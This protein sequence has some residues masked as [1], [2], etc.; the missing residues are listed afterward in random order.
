MMTPS[1]GPSTLAI[2]SEH[3]AFLKQFCAELADRQRHMRRLERQRDRQ[4]RAANADNYRPAGRVKPG[5]LTWHKSGRQRR[6]DARLAEL[7]RQLAAHRQSLH[8]QLVNDILA[9]GDQIYLEQLSY[10]AFQRRFG[11]SVGADGVC[12]WRVLQN[13]YDPIGRVRRAYSCHT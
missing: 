5:S 11:R 10:R 2:V 13:S 3:A 9:L 8:G 1:D 7:H 4:R 6:T 12:T